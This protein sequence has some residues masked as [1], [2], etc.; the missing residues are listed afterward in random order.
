MLFTFYKVFRFPI[1]ILLLVVLKYGMVVFLILLKLTK[2]T[3][4]YLAQL[5]F[6]HNLI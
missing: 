4:H 5:T 3:I 2:S 6:I 1:H